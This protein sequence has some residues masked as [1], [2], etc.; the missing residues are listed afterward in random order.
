M[1][2]ESIVSGMFYD[3]EKEDLIKQIKQC[4]TS[5]FGPGKL[6]KPIGNKTLFGCIVPHAGFTFSGMAAAHAYKEIA[7]SR[8]PDLF[9]ILGTDHTGIE[10]TCASADD[11]SVPTGIVKN[12]K[13]F[14]K[15]LIANGIKESATNHADEHSIEVQLPF[16]QFVN[17]DPKICPVTI[18]PDKDYKEIAAIIN[19]TVKETKVK[20]IIII[21]SDFT[22]YGINYNY[23]PFT[24][25]IKANLYKLDKEAIDKILELDPEAFLDHIRKTKATICGYNA[26][27]VL[28]E[29]CRLNNIKTAN[30]L[31]YYT[32][33]DVVGDFSSAVGYA[34]IIFK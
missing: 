28:L 22:H 17:K 4:F 23:V 1:V 19:Q 21:S 12:H 30:L 15:A 9:I 20:P 14:T 29:L 27:A 3:G 33:G 31:K 5:K 25:N 34:S 8:Q 2:R 16:L 26:I 18:S 11:W 24:T 7:E 6:P 32:S 10:G 13:D